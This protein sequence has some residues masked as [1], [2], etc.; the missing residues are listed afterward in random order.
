[1]HVTGF[2]ASDVPD[3][4]RQLETGD[5]PRNLDHS[6]VGSWAGKPRKRRST[7]N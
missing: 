6:D 5:V 7:R 1:M 2:N 4:N 3:M